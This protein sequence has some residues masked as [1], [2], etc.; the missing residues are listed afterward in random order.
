MAVTEQ[1]F[2]AITAPTDLPAVRVLA[3][4]GAGKTLVIENRVKYLLMQRVP[5]ERIAV[6]TL[7]NA[8]ATEMRERIIRTNPSVVNSPLEDHICTIH[9][10]CFRLLKRTLSRKW[11]VARTGD[12][13]RQV[14][15]LV[16]LVGLDGNGRSGL[17]C[18]P[19]LLYAW[20]CASKNAGTTTQESREWYLRMA[21]DPVT[22]QAL[23]DARKRLDA[24]LEG[25]GLIT[26][27]DM[28]LEAEILL[29]NPATRRALSGK[30][31]IVDEGQ[32]TGSQA[33]RVL[34]ALAENGQFYVVGDQDQ[35]LFAF[36]GA[37][38][39]TN[40]GLGFESRY[41]GGG[42]YM[43]ETNF[44]STQAIV[45]TANRAVDANY[46][47]DTAH[48]RKTLRPCTDAPQGDKMLF[49]EFATP[50]DEA[51][52]VAEMVLGE[53]P[54]D[55]FVAARTRAALSYMER[56][57]TI[58]SVPFV[59]LNGSGFWDLRHVRY[60]VSYTVLASTDDLPEK[61]LKAAYEDVYNVAS[62]WMKQPFDAK[63][64]QGEVVAARGSYCN[65]RYLGRVFLDKY[66]T[67]RD[68]EASR[69][70]VE[71]RF[72]NGAANLLETVEELRNVYQQDGM[73]GTMQWVA[74]NVV[75]PWVQRENGSSDVD[76]SVPE[77]LEVAVELA[78]HSADLAELLAFVQ[79]SREAVKDEEKAKD[80]VV[81]GTIHKLKGRERPSMHLVGACQRVLPTA[82]ALGLVH[83]R[84]GEMPSPTPQATLWDERCC[85]YVAITRAKTSVTIT[86]P[87]LWR[88]KPTQ[89]SMFV[90]EVLEFLDVVQDEDD[91]PQ[92][93]GDRC[94]EV[95][96]QEILHP[97][98]DGEEE[99]VDEDQ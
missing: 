8:M 72:R 73:V 59:N 28:L 93:E 70:D 51:S 60:L 52:W 94:A 67:Y 10:L 87:L 15:D 57:L 85:F 42:T 3:G 31:V 86:A 82:Y 90:G 99:D 61:V 25:S 19:D 20:I 27:A 23:W 74:E 69:D 45:D 35:T 4:P 16:A 33:M 56:A 79:K 5:P 78:E 66:P 95:E 29:R 63:N 91:T 96:V 81:I 71:F 44:R 32:D 62:R 22:G 97:E 54:A 21:P 17:V 39:D 89:R 26:F 14:K 38:P 49:R 53:T 37:T 41:P 58:R 76:G 68:L 11:E 46:T 83:V 13:H 9:A 50:L 12:V 64:P 6:V 65:H 55:V 75:L 36:T 30:Y 18:S 77:D 34:S 7:T 92:F 43:L 2:A 48:L 84:P 88:N 80:V 1:Q 98:E 47:E 24:W 40:I